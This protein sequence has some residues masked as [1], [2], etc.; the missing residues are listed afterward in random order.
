MSC[1]KKKCAFV[2]EEFTLY[3]NLLMERTFIWNTCDY[4]VY[5]SPTQFTETN[6]IVFF[7]L[8][9]PVTSKTR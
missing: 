2:V 9:I 6:H 3:L 4:D 5:N 8:L 7:E 1:Q